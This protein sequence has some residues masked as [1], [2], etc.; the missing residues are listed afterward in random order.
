MQYLRIPK[1][2][3]ISE[4]KSN[5]SSFSAG[6]Y[7][8]ISIPNR[9]V[10]TVCD[11]LHHTKPFEKG[12]EPGSVWYLHHSTHFLI[13]TKALQSHS[14]LIY[15]KGDSIIPINP[16][17]FED[18]Q[19]K[20]GDILISKDSNVGECVIVHGNEFKKHMFSG[21]IVRLNP[22]IDR[23][24]L[25]AFLKHPIFKAQL[26]AKVPRGAT[27]AHA[28][29]LWLDCLIPFPDQ[30]DEDKV[31]NYIS[32]LTQAIIEKEIAIRKRHESIFFLIDTELKKSRSG[33]IFK[34]EYPSIEEIRLTS[35]LDTGLYCLGF[36]SFKYNIE[37]YIHGITCLSKMGI[38]SR[39][40]PNLAVSVIG[41]SLYS[42]E[43]KKGW[44]QLI[45]PINISEYG[46]LVQRE[47]LGSPQKLP[48]VKKNDIIL[49]C[50]GFEKGRTFVLI[51]PIE[52][53]T[54]NFHG[55]VLYWPGAELWQII[56]V[57][58]F[59][60]YLREYGIVDWVGVGGSG[61]HMSPE[62]FDYLPFPKFPDDVQQQIATLYHH[63]SQH[64]QEKLT[65]FNFIDWHRRWNDSLGVWELNREMKSLQAQLW[66]VQSDIIDG[67]TIRIDLS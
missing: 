6:M 64:P 19:L 25:F 32:V 43:E 11:L 4:I 49:G 48:M 67:K 15:P 12:T 28:K 29:S 13:R 40:G 23:F 18:P 51:D 30:K 54:T 36:R 35:R 38:Q 65:Q 10:K 42:E 46:T 60:A 16:R 45:R 47:W 39:R 63:S 55:T 17:I 37:K 24:Y 3:S 50:E 66:K 31:L 41:K 26:L 5:G 44:Y 52:Q 2:V 8:S 9:K 20:D 27:I 56:F 58:C 22:K 14:C 53:C 61:G 21:G 62:Y 34:Y 7:H 59:L 1:E 33:T 57:R